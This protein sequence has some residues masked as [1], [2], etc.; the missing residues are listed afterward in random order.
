ME[1]AFR[2]LYGWHL[3]RGAASW[4]SRDQVRLEPEC[5][6]LHTSSH[7]AAALERYHRAVEQVLSGAVARHA[8]AVAAPVAVQI[9][10]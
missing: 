2:A 8:T 4:Q 10:R 3:R 5:L 9:G 6:K 7:R 1:R